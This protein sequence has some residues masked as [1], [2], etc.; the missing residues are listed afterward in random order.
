MSG[1]KILHILVDLSINENFE[2]SH[3]VLW[4][5]NKTSMVLCWKVS[6][7]EF[8]KGGCILIE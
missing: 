6:E 3:V 7:K 8:E 1:G 4:L 2:I 5:F